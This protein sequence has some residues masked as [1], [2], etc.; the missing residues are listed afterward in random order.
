MD[1]KEL[2][3][4]SISTAVRNT[5]VITIEKAEHRTAKVVNRSQTAL[6]L[7]M[8]DWCGDG[9]RQTDSPVRVAR[10]P[11]RQQTRIARQ[12]QPRICSP[13]LL[14]A[15]STAWETSAKTSLPHT[16]TPLGSTSLGSADVTSLV[17]KH[18][19]TGATSR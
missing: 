11:H 10:L 2:V 16:F 1:R 4:T 18:Y 6:M 15:V 19:D 14:A 8:M 9:N 5:L 3:L 17:T 13:G 12:A 7:L